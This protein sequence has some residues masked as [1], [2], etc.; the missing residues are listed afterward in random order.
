MING[1]VTETDTQLE[2]LASIIHERKRQ[3]NKWGPVPRIDHDFGKW[4]QILME[5]IGE[6]SA[7]DLA[8][9]WRKENK[10]ARRSV[11][12]YRSKIDQE[13]I[14][15]ASVIVAW[16]EHRV[17]GYKKADEVYNARRND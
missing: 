15:A 16:L 7:E 17:I 10:V 9:E 4:L 2:I 13:L 6:A 1:L 5:E 8:D 11:V 3:D 12:N 14:Q